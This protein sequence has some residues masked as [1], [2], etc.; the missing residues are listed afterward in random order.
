MRGMAGGTSAFHGGM[1]EP[2]GRPLFRV[3][4]DAQGIPFVRQK[5]FIFRTVR[6][7]A[8]VAHPFSKGDMVL[9]APRSQVR[10]DMTH[11]AKLFSRHG[12]AKRFRRI[13][14]IMTDITALCGDGIMRTCLQERLLL[15]RVRIM[16]DIAGSPPY[17]IS[18][19]RVGKGLVALVVAG[20][21]EGVFSL[22][23]KV[24]FL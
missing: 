16:T 15:R 3:A 20:K 22:H 8:R 21:A 1:R 24:F 6:V 10:D 19:M 2:H 12:C 11:R 7:M 4:G 13:R 5:F 17:R 23:E 9:V 18:S 14:R